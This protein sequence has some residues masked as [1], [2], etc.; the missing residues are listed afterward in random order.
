[1]REA[2]IH[3]GMHKTGSTSIQDTLHGYRKSGTSYAR[4]K[5]PN[6]SIPITTIFSDR[7][8]PHPIHIRNGRTT[9][10]IER[11]KLEYKAALDADCQN[12]NIQKLII[13]GEDIYELS[14]KSLTLLRDYLEKYFEKISL[15]AY[16]RE[17]ES[18]I[19]SALQQIIKTGSDGRNLPKPRYRD[20]FEKILKVFGAESITFKK[21]DKSELKNQSVVS[22]FCEF[23]GIDY[24][25]IKEKKSNESLSTEVIRFLIR[26]NRSGIVTT[27]D[28][29]LIATRNRLVKLL[30]DRFKGK[31]SIP[32]STL[33]PLIDA[34]DVK[35]MENVSN[36]DLTSKATGDRTNT[37]VTLE[38]YL[39][40]I[41]NNTKEE[42]RDFIGSLG[43]RHTKA[44][45]IPHLLNRLYLHELTNS[46]LSSEERG[47][48]SD[49]IIRIENHKD[50]GPEIAN[51]LRK[52][53]PP[54][55]TP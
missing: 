40:S 32:T 7:A 38:E 34:E 43:V 23:A 12:Q 49:A 6:H 3:L 24:S 17:P 14:P 30:A 15:V 48:I 28:P 54:K 16:L 10:E 21:F 4:L 33:T 46:N 19:T 42:L 22:D 13:S 44:D 8:T 36:I 50:F 18:Y 11:L 31:F 41:P 35:W 20:R 27:G 55:I 29:L 25:Q 53:L 1:M 37:E 45:T 9:E 2:L 26:L 5:T 47:A 51:A 52:A 39:T